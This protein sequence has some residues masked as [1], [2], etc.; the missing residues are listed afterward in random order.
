[1]VMAVRIGGAA[2]E[3]VQPQPGDLLSCW[4]RRVM[5]GVD[6]VEPLVAPLT[7]DGRIRGWWFYIPSASH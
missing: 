1:M 3:H 2:V 7:H 4:I 5:L 6:D